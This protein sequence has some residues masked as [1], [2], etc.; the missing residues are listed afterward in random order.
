MA[1]FLFDYARNQFLLGGLNWTVT[2]N[3]GAYSAYLID[4][5]TW[6]PQQATSQFLSEV[7]PGGARM[8]GPQNL[9]TTAPGAGVA[10]ASSIT[11]PAVA[12]SA[13]TIDGLLI[14]R[15]T[16][17]E[18]TSTLIAW[19]DTDS[20]GSTH[21]PFAPNGSDVVITWDTGANKIFKL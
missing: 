18:A 17:T 1:S 9:T 15:N 4:S 13:T 8:A 21:F 11:F 7:T 12:T 2:P 10:N 14:Y 19:I 3:P 5:G 16:G 20:G 6:T